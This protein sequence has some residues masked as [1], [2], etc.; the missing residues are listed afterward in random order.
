MKSYIY[1]LDVKN[2]S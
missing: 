2:R 1:V